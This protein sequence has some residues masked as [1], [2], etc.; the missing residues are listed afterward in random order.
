MSLIRTFLGPES[1]Y[2]KSLPFT[3]L[4][5]LPVV[6]GDDELYSYFFSDTICGLV[7]YLDKNDIEPETV[8]L[9]GVYLKQEIPLDINLCTDSKGNW[10]S[11]PDIC[12]SLETHFKETLEERYKGH[13]EE[14]DCAFDDRSSQGSRC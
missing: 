1:K 8:Q 7:E 2:D 5:M 9:R 4:A 12:K 14:G 10:L 3:Y 13:L 6:E 11:R